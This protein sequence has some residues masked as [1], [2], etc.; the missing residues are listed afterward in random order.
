MVT[1]GVAVVRVCRGSARAHR[2]E[3][4]SG[5]TTRSSFGNRRRADGDPHWN[6]HPAPA[7]QPNPGKVMKPMFRHYDSVFLYVVLSVALCCCQGRLG[8][9]TRPITAS[10]ETDKQ[11]VAVGSPL[12]MHYRFDIAP[13]S[14]PI[15][16]NNTVFVHF[17][18]SQGELLF[19]DDHEP[20]TPTSSWQ[21]GTTIE[22][23][24]T[25]FVPLSSPPGALSVQI[26]LYDPDTG[27]R[28]RLTGNGSGQTNHGG[29]P[30]VLENE[31]TP[32]RIK[33]D[34]GWYGIEFSADNPSIQWRWSDRIATFSFN[35]PKMDSV[36]YLFADTH[37]E[38][39][40]DP[41]E[42]RIQIGRLEIARFRVGTGDPVLRRIHI[43]GTAL[44]ATDRVVLN[45]VG[46]KAFIPSKQ[47]MG[48]DERRLSLRVY[49]L[50]IEPQPYAMSYQLDVASLTPRR[51]PPKPFQREYDF[52][53]N[54][55]T[56][57]IPVWK[58]ALAP[59][60]GQPNLHYLEVGP[61]EGQATVWMLENVL[62]HPSSRATG[63]DLFM[64]LE[65]VDGATIKRRF[66]DNVKRAGAADRVRLMI[67]FSQE[68]LRK[69]PIDSFDIIYIDGSHMADDVLE[70][71]VLAW[72][73]LRNDGV[74]IFDDYNWP[75]PGPGPKIAI[76]VFMQLF[77]RHFEIVHTRYQMIIRKRESASSWEAR[78]TETSPWSLDRAVR[79]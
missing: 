64:G 39:F 56:P 63:I 7:R 57:N 8:E 4:F 26:G 19:T 33:F 62:T 29:A 10:F 27:N 14:E 45:F 6:R 30:I 37:A 61:F 67:G 54:W 21:S 16:K 73:L 49:K 9:E 15:S 38:A 59:F 69:L 22:Y 48:D 12:E 75:R 42:V 23:R 41:L 77:G 74:I 34:E 50:W 32:V 28:V 79:R 17:V 65:D 1:W 68:Q 66:L 60:V 3:A 70:D 35:N 47:R 51:T 2:V 20:P 44:G 13:E 43:P 18:N 55:F 46:D 31:D 5:T 24:R 72:R 71:A 76:N 40:N 78:P 36:M 25:F 52:T 53:K 11:R 58:K